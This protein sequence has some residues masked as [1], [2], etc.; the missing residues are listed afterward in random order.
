MRLVG[1]SEY[2]A[3]LRRVR[4]DV[5][6]VLEVRRIAEIAERGDAVTL[7]VLRGGRRCEFRRGSGAG[8][9]N[10]KI[11]SR[12]HARRVFAAFSASHH[13]MVGNAESPYFGISAGRPYRSQRAVRTL[14]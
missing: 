13:Q 5:V 11:T 2:D 9:Q 4:I 14:P 7:C 12:D 1:S 6:E 8:G 3:A 10:E